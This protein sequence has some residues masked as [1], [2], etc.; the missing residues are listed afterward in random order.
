MV[1]AQAQT[2]TV[3]DPVPASTY[4]DDDLIDYDDDVLEPTKELDAT[5]AVEFGAPP[6]DTADIEV[7]ALDQPSDAPTPSDKGLSKTITVTAEEQ[8]AT[9]E[10]TFEKD[11]IDYDDEEEVL[12]GGSG[13]A[14]AGGEPDERVEA[15]QAGQQ[16]VHDQEDEEIDFGISEDNVETQ[17]DVADTTDEQLP[18]VASAN[19][20]PDGNAA[21]QEE[22][23]KG[24]KKLVTGIDE[25]SAEA[26]AEP[27]K[28]VQVPNDLPQSEEPHGQTD[29][30]QADLGQKDEITWEDP[31]DESAMETSRHADHSTSG[32][33][34]AEKV[35]SESEVAQGFVTGE[36]VE[37]GDHTY[38]EAD[39]IDEEEYPAI[40][41]Q[42][43][44]EE[45]PLFSITSEGFFTSTSI[46]HD[47]IGSLLAGFRDELAN[48]IAT[49]DELVF[50]I[51]ELGL[52]YA[53][54][55]H[56]CPILNTLANQF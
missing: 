22:H 42:Y 5:K 20:E 55:S 45:F 7:T 4:D 15:E 19:M 18:S 44:G 6:N 16:T 46:L 13:F 12:D 1:N 2:A 8:T 37:V 47:N 41:V 26:T 28:P 10:P 39:N 52:E 9:N 53:E 31:E 48:E 33:V 3:P 27:S 11:E 51:D 38:D 50:Q 30:S 36:Q 40:T 17:P 21:A 49:E 54:V 23:G 32:K 56:K 34:G 25:G 24:G 14:A 35:V 43:K 29:T